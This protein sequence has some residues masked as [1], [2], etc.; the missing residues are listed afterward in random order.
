MK[1]ALWSVC[2]A[3]VL[4]GLPGLLL[5]VLAAGP[6]MSDLS[7]RIVLSGEIREA[8]ARLRAAHHLVTE[9]KWADAL[10]AYQRLIHE[11]GDDLVPQP[12]DEEAVFATR[13]SA[14]LRWWCH[15]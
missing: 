7:H 4:A 2:S 11:A 13:R 8:A 14:R 15:L 12:A 5:S 1:T 3:I 10:D 9:K 6:G